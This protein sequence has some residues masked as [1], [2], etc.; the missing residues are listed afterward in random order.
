MRRLL[1]LLPVVLVV[2]ACGSDAPPQVTFAAGAGERVV[3]GAGVADQRH[4]MREVGVGR[5]AAFHRVFPEPA[6]FRRTARVGEDNGK[7][8]LAFAEI[9]AG[10]LAQG[11]RVR[12]VVDRVVDELERD[13][14]VAAVRV[15]R[16]FLVLPHPEV[17]RFWQQKATDP[18]RWLAGVRRLTAVTPAPPYP[19]DPGPPE[20]TE[21]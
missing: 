10:V 15:E 3:D 7:R 8:H 17:A 4:C 20:E 5:A 16:R 1:A 6:I 11:R 18:E 9:V 13:A 19:G 21:R 14:Q 2:A 12:D